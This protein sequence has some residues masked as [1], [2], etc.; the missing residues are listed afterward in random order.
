MTSIGVLIFYFIVFCTPPCSRGI[1]TSNNNCVCDP[2][3][4]GSRCRT[5]I[6]TLFIINMVYF[7]IDINECAFVTCDQF[8]NNTEG[9]YACYCGPGYEILSDNSTCRGN[10]T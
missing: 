7:L 3:W 10:G 8:C 2:G 9:S 6:H 5:G 4:T 1:C